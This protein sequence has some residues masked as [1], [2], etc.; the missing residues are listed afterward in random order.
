MRKKT[1]ITLFSMLLLLTAFAPNSGAIE[2]ILLNFDVHIEPMTSVPLEF[3]YQHYQQIKGNMIW[4]A[5]TCAALTGCKLS[6]QS[7]GEFMEY[8][9]E[10]ADT[11]LI[12]HYL[13]EGHQ[14]GTHV[15]ADIHL[16][17]HNWLYV[18]TNC[19]LDTAHLVWEDNIEMIELLL[20]PSENNCM[21]S[22]I[23]G[24]L[25][26]KY[27][28][29]VEYG[30]EITGGGPTEPFMGYFGHLPWNP[31]R[32]SPESFLIE[33]VN[34]R[35]F[36]QVPHFPQIGMTG[37]HGGGNPSY[38]DL[39]F[40][41]M[42]SE[43]LK[44]FLEWRRHDR[45]NDD[46]RVWT[47]GWNTHGWQTTQYRDVIMQFLGWMN[48][49]FVN[50][51]SPYGSTIAQYA[52]FNQVRDSFYAWED[53]NPGASSFSYEPG[54]PYP[55]SYPFLVEFLAYNKYIDFIPAWQ[56]LGISCH[57][58]VDSSGNAPRWVLY[59]NFGEETIDFN[60][61]Y[62]GMMHV[63]DPVTGEVTP[64]QSTGVWVTEEPIILTLPPPPVTIDLEYLNGSPVPPM[65]GLLHYN[66][67][68]EN[69][70]S[71]PQTFDAWLEV[72]YQGGQP[73]TIALR[74][75][76]NFLPVWT[77]N[78]D[79]MIFPVPEYYVPGN[80]FFA[81]IIGE[82]PMYASSA[83]GFPFVKLGNPPGDTYN[84]PVPSVLIDPFAEVFE[85]ETIT[86]VPLQKAALSASPN[87]F[88]PTTA[89]SIQL[90]AFSHVNLSVYN[91][92]GQKVETLIDGWR[93]AGV[94][95]VTFDGSQLASGV[96]LYSLEV[97]GEAPP[98]YGIG[99]MM[100]V[101]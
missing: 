5:D 83:D 23:P 98:T 33:D 70:S 59:K 85:T 47:F 73:T 69:N 42:Q 89:I 61:I 35:D 74:H 66:L 34:Q 68:V 80:Y 77:I 99:K 71:V 96:Y 8:L 65:G 39:I 17:P 36:F 11:M 62:Q 44:C 58:L 79:N 100:L 81:G 49:H 48:Q 95:E 41:S 84:P 30:F 29:M 53:A 13:M 82:H 97:S 91:L 9:W 16:G 26:D 4:L 19:S 43:F 72:S 88:N 45:L 76:D 101:K 64:V 51:T 40:E 50:H 52:S 24:F 60:S 92:A 31:S 7:N 25:P 67:L 20:P 94:H 3:R 12:P 87:P 55:Y 86:A 93:E 10:E 15:H 78:R 1:F 90:S 27:D 46:N 56:N 63:L 38:F 21:S 37:L 22:Q 32:P 6:V 75:F 28:F 57:A 18:G 14:W 2:P 54:Q